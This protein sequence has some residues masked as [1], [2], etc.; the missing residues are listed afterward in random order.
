MRQ[1]KAFASLGVTSSGDNLKSTQIS[2]TNDLSHKASAFTTIG[3]SSCS[4]Y[5]KTSKP[6]CYPVTYINS[7]EKSKVE[8]SDEDVGQVES[9]ILSSKASYN[10]NTELNEH[11]GL[12]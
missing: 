6:P 5:H 8:Q 12:K 10:D 1:H 9:Q 11:S 7:H 4:L 2:R 3:V